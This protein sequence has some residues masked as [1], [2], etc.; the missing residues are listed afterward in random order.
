MLNI[1]V[2][3]FL[4]LRNRIY[5]TNSGAP[6]GSEISIDDFIKLYIIFIIFCIEL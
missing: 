4:Y 1:H 5:L 3:I 6:F 2:R